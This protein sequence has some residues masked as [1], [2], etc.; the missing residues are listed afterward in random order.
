MIYV[1]FKL[2]YR[3]RFAKVIAAEILFYLRTKA[4]LFQQIKKIVSKSLPAI[5]QTRL[6]VGRLRGDYGIRPK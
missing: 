2:Y 4:L 3:S 5:R 6:K 1:P